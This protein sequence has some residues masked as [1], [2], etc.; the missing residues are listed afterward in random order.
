MHDLPETVTTLP[1]C[2]NTPHN[3]QILKLVYKL[4]SVTHLLETAVGL[5]RVCTIWI[6]H[7][8]VCVMRFK[9]QS[10]DQF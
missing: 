7:T 6:M 5:C 10:R 1:E 4:L 3:A 8:E 2:T 9:V